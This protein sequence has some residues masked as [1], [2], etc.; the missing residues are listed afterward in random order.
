MAHA[1][2]PVL[3]FLQLAKPANSQEWLFHC[4]FSTLVVP[5][6]FGSAGSNSTGKGGNALPS[7]EVRIMGLPGLWEVVP[8]DD[9]AAL[10]VQAI[11][12]SGP[13]IGGGDIFVITQKIVS[14]AEGRIVKL[15]SVEPSPLAQRWAAAHQKDERVVEVILRETHRILR[16]D[17]GILITET[18]QGFVCA[19]A[20]V[21]ASNA[22][23]G[24][25]TLLPED[26]DQSARR[27]HAQLEKAF[28][29]RLAV[30]ISDT[31]GRAWREGLVNVALGV[32]GLAPLLDYRGQ[33]DVFGRALQVTVIAVA[34]ELASAAELVMGKTS[35]VPV[36]VIQGFNYQTAQGSGRELLRP[37]ELDLFR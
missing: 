26:P 4:F 22:P 28:G 20:G 37:A 34:D 30:I 7:P 17:R 16:M 14:K 18:R 2:L 12:A 19:N 27:L 1:L 8:G 6:Q 10:I 23:E 3:C 21:D 32:A 31:F 33:P 15:D 11:T 5:F 29:V 35:R 9:L 24:S 13:R 36:A 25:V